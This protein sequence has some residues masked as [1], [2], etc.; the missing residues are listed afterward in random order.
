MLEGRRAPEIVI[1]LRCS[2]KSTED[3]CLDKKE[4]EDRFDK[5]ME[6]RKKLMLENREKDFEEKKKEV[7]EANK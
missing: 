3:R 4:L 7:E 2:A 1:I 5:L 6:E